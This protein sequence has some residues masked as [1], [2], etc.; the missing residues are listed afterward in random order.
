MDDRLE[1]F[2]KVFDRDRVIDVQE[3][4]SENIGGVTGPVLKSVFDEVAEGNDETSEI[5][6]FDNNVG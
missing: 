1:L 6:Y 5:P 3:G 4:G 2:A